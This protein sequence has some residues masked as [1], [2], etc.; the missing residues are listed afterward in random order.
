MDSLIDINNDEK[1]I[2]QSDEEDD[3]ED[4]DNDDLDEEYDEEDYDLVEPSDEIDVVNVKSLKNDVTI[5]DESK[6]ITSDVIQIHEYAKIIG[7][8]AT[9]IDHDAPI[10]INLTVQQSAIE[11]AEAELIKGK[12][13]L[14]FLRYIDQDKKIAELRDP[15][16]M[17]LPK[18]INSKLSLASTI[19]Y[20]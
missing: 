11:I 7:I 14:W 5:L 4:G 9:H 3:I 6:Y 12:C 1:H 16:K 10:M 2:Q 8:R 17:A 19:T 15:N 20:P 13:P 18:S